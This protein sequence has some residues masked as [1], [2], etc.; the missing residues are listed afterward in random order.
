M[1]KIKSKPTGRRAGRRF[2]RLILTTTRQAGGHPW[3]D[4]A[5]VN[6]DDGNVYR[7]RAI[8]PSLRRQYDRPGGLAWVIG[9][10]V[11]S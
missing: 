11:P 5:G 10:R 1:S 6:D 4:Q 3:C 7:A 8:R 9:W 2:G